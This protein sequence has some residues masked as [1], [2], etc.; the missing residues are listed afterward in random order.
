MQDHL[1]IAVA[2]RTY[3]AYRQLLDSERWQRLANAGAHP[4]RLL[5]ADT[6]TKDPAAADVL[7]IKALAAPFTINT[8]PDA[9]L[10]A[11]ADHGKLGKL[12]PVDGGDADKMI[13]SSAKRASTMTNWPPICSAKAPSRSSNPGRSCS[14]LSR[15]KTFRSK[16]RVEIRSDETKNGW[17]QDGSGFEEKHPSPFRTTLSSCGGIEK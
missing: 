14:V 10:L 9:T 8:I 2:K 17:T 4:Q 11:F 16:P 3:K 1:G 6:G 12:L 7:Y 5:W 15:R 13:A